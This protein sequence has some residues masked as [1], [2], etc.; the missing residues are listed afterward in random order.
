MSDS[1][2]HTGPLFRRMPTPPAPL[3]ATEQA[4][5]GTPQKRAPGTNKLGTDQLQQQAKRGPV[6]LSALDGFIER[7]GGMLGDKKDLDRLFDE[8]ALK[9]RIENSDNTVH[10][11]RKERLIEQAIESGKPVEFMNSAKQ[12]EEVSVKRTGSKD[13]KDLYEVKVGKNSFEVKLPP[14]HDAVEE[15]A[16]LTDYYTQTPEHLRDSLKQVVVEN[17]RN[18]NDEYWAEVYDI[19]GFTSGATG[20]NGTM[21]FYHGTKNIVQALFDHEMGHIAGQKSE[22]EQDQWLDGFFEWITGAPQNVPEGWQEAAKKD[23]NHVSDYATKSPSED[24]AETYRFYI[25]AKR[26]GPEA[27]EDFREEYPARAKLLDDIFANDYK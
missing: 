4:P 25:E 21:T 7:Q 9:R 13:G 1:R 18:P 10:M 27:F 14:E 11:S 23:G 3:P 6:P 2:L 16:K 22:G 19:P 20:G 15:I 5:A 8:E 17:G 26:N 12:T 24:F